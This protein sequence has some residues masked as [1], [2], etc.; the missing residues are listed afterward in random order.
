[1]WGPALRLARYSMPRIYGRCDLLRRAECSRVSA[2]QYFSKRI[3]GPSCLVKIDMFCLVELCLVLTCA[4]GLCTRRSSIL[5]ISPPLPPVCRRFWGFG[6]ACVV[7]KVVGGVVSGEHLFPSLYTSAV[8]W[9]AQ[10]WGLMPSCDV[11][12]CCGD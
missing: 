10:Q 6:R 3:L 11:L 9:S 7:Q 8:N 2:L 4:Y 12:M 5:W 1:L